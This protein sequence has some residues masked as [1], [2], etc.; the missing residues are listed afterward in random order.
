MTSCLGL[1]AVIP[2]FSSLRQVPHRGW[3]LGVFPRASCFW[4]HGAHLLCPR[5]PPVLPRPKPEAL[6]APPPSCF[7]L[8]FV[9]SR[10]HNQVLW[11]KPSPMGPVE[12][13]G[14]P[15]PQALQGEFT[16]PKEPSRPPPGRGVGHVEPGR[17][18]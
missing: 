17:F 4:V 14:A 18:D 13:S 10:V 1:R 12:A 16:N 8:P 6:P 11:D 2:R 3:S 9:D 7:S 15:G 5:H